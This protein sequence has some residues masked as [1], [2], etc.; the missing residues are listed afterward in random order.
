MERDS[1]RLG[2]DSLEHR[3]KGAIRYGLSLLAAELL[4]GEKPK[5]RAMGDFFRNLRQK[6]SDVNK[7]PFSYR[8]EYARIL[9]IVDRVK[10]SAQQ[11]TERR[12]IVH[13][14]DKNEPDAAVSG[15]VPPG[16]DNIPGQRVVN[17]PSVRSQESFE[18]A[19]RENNELKKTVGE[20]HDQGK[21][22]F[23]RH[24]SGEIVLI[25]IGAAAMTSV[26]GVLLHKLQKD[27]KQ[28]EDK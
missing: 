25:V 10:F 6:G 11:V 2:R 1:R 22:V 7:L 27:H 19:L 20:L 9:G 13:T 3:N 26:T 14:H 28:H 21:R 5:G 23:A 18:A 17:D 8:E 16:L 12:E 24:G 4:I 15:E